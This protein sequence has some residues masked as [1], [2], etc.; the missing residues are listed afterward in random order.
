[1]GA[2]S[3]Y[4]LDNS[5]DMIMNAQSEWENLKGCDD[6][7]AAFAMVDCIKTETDQALGDEC[8]HFNYAVSHYVTGH[9][10]TQEGNHVSLC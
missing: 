4:G 3:V 8:G 5:V 7:E 10:E 9:C 1:M 6:V 2:S